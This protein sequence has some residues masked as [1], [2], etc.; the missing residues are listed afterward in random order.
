MPNV[1]DLLSQLSSHDLR[2]LLS[3]RKLH[4]A[5]QVVAGRIERLRERLG[6][7]E[8][9]L[10]RLDRKLAHL[11]E[12][13]ARAPEPA[14]GRPPRRAP[15]RGSLRGYLVQALEVIA[16]PASARELAQLALRAG[17]KTR[18]AFDVFV[19]ATNQALHVNKEFLR[20][21]DGKYTLR[22]P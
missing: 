6:D 3:A 19:R 18:S 9:L 10:T 8:T 2:R 21:P 17:Y 5:R 4:A 11:V 16:K 20:G 14:G 22:R 15:R 13:A 1:R 12:R 7:A